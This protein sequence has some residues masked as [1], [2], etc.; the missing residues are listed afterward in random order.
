MAIC[1][2]SSTF[3]YGVVAC[4]I[5]FGARHV[6]EAVS[7]PASVIQSNVMYRLSASA[8]EIGRKKPRREQR[9]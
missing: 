6:G 3:G 5:K 2:P 4:P 7:F 8:F 9:T 1:F